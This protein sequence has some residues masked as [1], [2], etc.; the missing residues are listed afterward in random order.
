MTQWY[1]PSYEP[2]YLADVNATLHVH[3]YLVESIS[4]LIDERYTSLWL[5]TNPLGNDFL[6]LLTSLQYLT[7]ILSQVLISDCEQFPGCLLEIQTMNIN[8]TIRIVNRDDLSTLNHQNEETNTNVHFQ[9]ARKNLN[10]TTTTNQDEN[11]NS[12]ITLTRRISRRKST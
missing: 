1:S 2:F 5:E 6:R 12:K 11:H 4:D 7:Q 8:Q 9:N 3:R 10:R